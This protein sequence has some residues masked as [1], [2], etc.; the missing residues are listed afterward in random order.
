MEDQIPTQML[1]D[2]EQT[3]YPEGMSKRQ[4]VSSGASERLLNMSTDQQLAQM[5]S[6]Y[7][8]LKLEH[9]TLQEKYR[10]LEHQCQVTEQDFAEISAAYDHERQARMRAEE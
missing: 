8:T 6:I 1:P 4:R 10:V 2:E 7:G 5:A 9:D 3:L